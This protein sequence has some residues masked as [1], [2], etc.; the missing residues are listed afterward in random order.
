MSFS[1]LYAQQASYLQ[2][3]GVH[4]WRI[5]FTITLHVKWNIRCSQC[6]RTLGPLLELPAHTEIFRSKNEWGRGKLHTFHGSERDNGRKGLIMNPTVN[7]SAA[8]E[9]LRNYGILVV[10][11]SSSQGCGEGGKGR[12]KKE[13]LR[14]Y[15]RGCCKAADDVAAPIW[16]AYIKILSMPCTHCTRASTATVFRETTS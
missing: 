1:F 7:V 16:P 8:S 6:T 4:T 3:L 2:E 13:G 5:D 14:G 15:V 9:L 10:L 11:S 12:G